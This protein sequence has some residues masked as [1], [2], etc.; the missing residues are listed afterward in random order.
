MKKLLLIF[1]FSLFSFQ[2]FGNEDILT[3]ATYVNNS[4]D[5]IKLNLVGRTTTET[6]SL[7]VGKTYSSN[8]DMLELITRENQLVDLNFSSG[9]KARIQPDSEFRVDL[10]NQVVLNAD[11]QPESLVFSDYMLNLA[12]MNGELYVVAPSYSSKSTMC[13]V[14]TPLANLELNG[15]KYLIKA[16]QKYVVVYIIDG[17]LGVLNPKNNKKDILKNG[18]MAFIVPFPGDG[19][20]VTS[21]DIDGDRISQ[22]SSVLKEIESAMDSVIFAIID[23]R[24]VGIKVK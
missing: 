13:I 2:L 6:V 18:Q 16:N 17:E 7:V 3:G 24:I 14:Q 12:L 8:T 20:M 21:K 10:F 19:V 22:Y 4:S 9:L 5:N 1:T 15:G 23:K 11:S